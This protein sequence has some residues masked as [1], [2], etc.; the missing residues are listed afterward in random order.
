MTGLRFTL[1]LYGWIPVDPEVGNA[2]ARYSTTLTLEEQREAHDF[3]FGGLDQ[4]RMMA[5]CDHSQELQPPK[6]TL[7][8][9][10]VD[11]QRG[12]LETGKKNIYFDKYNYLMEV[13]ELNRK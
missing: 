4:Y 11:F 8:S 6:N 7:R 9:D 10:D 5:N 2:I 1:H 3:D 13:E 12:E